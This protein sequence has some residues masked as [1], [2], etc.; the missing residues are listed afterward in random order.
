MRSYS[1]L[2]GLALLSGAY[3]N[4][5]GFMCSPALRKSGIVWFEKLIKRLIAD[6]STLV[7]GNVMV[8]QRANTP[9]DRADVLAYLRQATR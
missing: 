5:P 7:P 6:R 1:K 3:N 8:A 9:C 4:L 2:V